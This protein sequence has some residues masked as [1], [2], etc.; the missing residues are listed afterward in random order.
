MMSSANTEVRERK[1]KHSL[2]YFFKNSIII[3]W[4]GLS[5]IYRR[6]LTGT[7]IHILSQ[8]QGNKLNFTTSGLDASSVALYLG[9]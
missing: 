9:Y 1:N 8:Y 5:M 6:I 3:Q 2:E 4:S 7:L